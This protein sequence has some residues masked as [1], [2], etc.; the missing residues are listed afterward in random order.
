MSD[1]DLFYNF[2]NH[3][4]LDK[5]ADEYTHMCMCIP[6]KK[7]MIN[8]EEYSKFLELYSNV[9]GKI[10]LYITEVQ[11]DIGPVLLDFKFESE[12]NKRLY[13]DNDILNVISYCNE[14]LK[15]NNIDAYE[16]IVLEKKSPVMV[17]INKYDYKKNNYYKD[18]Y[19]IIFTVSINKDLRKT[20]FLKLINYFEN[21]NDD[22]IYMLEDKSIFIDNWFLYGSKKQTHSYKKGNDYEVTKIYDYKNQ[23]LDINKY[24]E[25]ELVNVLAIR[26]N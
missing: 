2:L 16:V 22:T 23:K 25:S 3:H 20:I 24:N 10:D 1:V 4:E 12:N 11:K 18:G 19:R 8:D 13:T 7:Y 17:N 6:N 9:I 14:A 21:L 5:N 15:E 26:K